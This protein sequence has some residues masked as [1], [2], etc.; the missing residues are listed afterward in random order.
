MDSGATRNSGG[1]HGCVPNLLVEVLERV[2]REFLVILFISIL[3]LFY[4]QYKS[5]IPYPM[6]LTEESEKAVI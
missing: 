6:Q 2:G 5:T 1:P 3:I 4:D